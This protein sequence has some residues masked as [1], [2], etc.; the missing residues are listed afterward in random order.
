MVKDQDY[1]QILGDSLA[2]YDP[3]TQSLKMS[4]LSLFGDLIESFATLPRSG[5]MRNGTVYQLPTLVRLTRGT[6]HG[7]L[8]PTPCASDHRDRGDVSNPS[9]QR[10]QR[11]GKQVG[12][13]MLF[14]GKPCPMCVEGM[15]GYPAEWTDLNSSAM[16]LTLKSP[17]SSAGQ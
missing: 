12:L 3:I 6:G 4:Q 1:G 8:L 17:K 5:T 10:R 16:P 9:I 11:I 14:K 13:S 15:M 7:L 2:K